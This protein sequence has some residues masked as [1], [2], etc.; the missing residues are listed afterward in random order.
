MTTKQKP[1]ARLKKECFTLWRLLIKRE[2]PRICPVCNKERT[3]DAHHFIG[4]V[5][6]RR[7]CFW[8]K[9]N[10]LGVG[11]ECH[12]YPARIKEWL[13]TNRPKQYTWLQKQLMLIR[14]GPKPGPIKPQ[15]YL[16]K[17]RRKLLKQL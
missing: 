3:W 6:W 10:G 15:Q 16:R 1:W 7:D 4:R 9:R 5:Y 2:S 17:I 8:D 14:A 11:R 12:K 13:R